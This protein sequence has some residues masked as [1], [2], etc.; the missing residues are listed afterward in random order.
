M[1]AMD[2]ARI[3]ELLRV[4]N[5]IDARIAAITDRPMTSGHLGEWIASQIF[6]IDLEPSAAKA[7]VDGRFR[8]GA[9]AGRTV[10]VKWYLKREGLVDVTESADLDYYL[11]LAGPPG[12]AVSSRGTVRPWCVTAVY[13]FDAERLLQQLRAAGV[14]I[15]TAS[16]VRAA[17]WDAAEIWPEDRR[18]D[19][20][21]DASQARQ[22]RLLS[23][24]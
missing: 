13:L 19:G 12:P 6:D 2:L 8:S 9:L 16:S 7:A 11:V 14:R 23:E 24:V 5:G 21:V 20:V 15:G 3:A 1:D 22:L 4:R 10:N 17:H 18:G